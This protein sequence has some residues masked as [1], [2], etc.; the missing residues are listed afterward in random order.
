MTSIDLLYRRLFHQK[1]AGPAFDKPEE[2]VSWFGA[3]QAQDYPGALWSVGL[4]M[5][6]ATESGIE[7]VIAERK[8]VRSWPMRGTL[9]FVSSGDIGWMLRLL[10]PKIIA[11]NMA[12]LKRMGIDEDT[13]KRSRKIFTRALQGGKIFTREGMYGLLESGRVS[14]SGMRGIHILWRLA[15]EGLI[16]SGPREGKQQTFVLLDEWIPKGRELIFEES[17]AEITRRYFTSHGPAT[18]EDFAWWAGLRKAEAKEGIESIKKE[19]VVEKVNDVAYWHAGTGTLFRVSR[20]PAYLLPGYDEY[21]VAYKDRSLLLEPT[22]LRQYHHGI[23][24]PKIIVDGRIAGSWSRRLNG[25]RV[26]I[27]LKLFSSLGKTIKHELLKTI[28]KY[29]D[30]LNRAVEIV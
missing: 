10:A 20:N 6:D 17:L 3:V 22:L 21:M 25:D 18:L 29:G 16:C 7:K 30:F 14:L 13:L 15:L 24:T 28:K 11:G 4:R 23:V 2:V 27:E 19:L 1:I 8:I 12:R 5:K 26:M 9:H